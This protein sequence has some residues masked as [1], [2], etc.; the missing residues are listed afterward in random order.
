MESGWCW[1]LNGINVKRESGRRLHQ[2]QAPSATTPHEK[3]SENRNWSCNNRVWQ[4]FKWSNKWRSEL[5]ESCSTNTETLM[6]WRFLWIHVGHVFEMLCG[7]KTHFHNTD[8]DKDIDTR[9]VWVWNLWLWNVPKKSN[10][11]QVNTEMRHYC[12]AARG[13]N[14]PTASRLWSKAAFSF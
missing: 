11:Q 5:S 8:E 13:Q 7:T 10:R 9:R 3:P 2:T 1:V 12:E 14:I 6:W 4:S